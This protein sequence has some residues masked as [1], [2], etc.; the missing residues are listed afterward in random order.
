ME[1]ELHRLRQH[2]TALTLALNTPTDGDIA[3][4]LGYL[5]ADIVEAEATWAQFRSAFAALEKLPPS[6]KPALP[7]VAPR[8]RRSDTH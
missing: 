4:L 2:L 1:I 5:E 3:R 7:T 6:A 8:R